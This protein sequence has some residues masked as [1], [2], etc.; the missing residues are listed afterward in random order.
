[1]ILYS[2]SY[3]LETLELFPVG[4]RPVTAAEDPMVLMTRSEAEVML[5]KENEKDSMP[6][7]F[8]DLKPL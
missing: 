4:R 1:M 7:I 5:R 2:E 3:L 8:L 6:L